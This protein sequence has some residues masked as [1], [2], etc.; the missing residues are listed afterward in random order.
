MPTCLPEFRFFVV[1]FINICLPGSNEVKLKSCD[2]TDKWFIVYHS[3]DAPQLVVVKL[4][5]NNGIKYVTNQNLSYPRPNQLN[6]RFQILN[7]QFL[8]EVK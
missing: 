8:Q 4:I 7:N 2:H 1:L 6:I 3:E 5:F